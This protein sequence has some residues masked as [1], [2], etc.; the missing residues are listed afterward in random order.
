MKR[1][2]LLIFIII[3]S[4]NIFAQRVGQKLTENKFEHKTLY[5]A[6]DS[7]NVPSPLLDKYDVKF[8]KLDIDVERNNVYVAGNVLMNAKVVTNVLDTFAFELNSALIIDSLFINNQSYTCIRTGWMV[9]VPITALNIGVDLTSQVYYHGTC[10]TNNGNFFSGISSLYDITWTLSESFAANEWFPVKQS[11][12]DKIDSAYIFVTTSNENK[13][14]SE[15]ILT[16]VVS[17]PNNKVRYEWKERIPL[18]YYLISVAVAKYVD[19]SI[20]AHP[21]GASDSLLIQNY[22][23]DDTVT[24]ANNKLLID[25]TRNYIEYYSTIF[26]M[27]PFLKE[28][29][30]HC[31]TPL[32]GGMEHQTMTTLGGFD[33]YL[34]THE[35]SH[36]WFG[37]NVTCATWSDIWL[38]EGF[39]SYA[40]CLSAN[41]FISYAEAQVH[42]SD[43]HADIMSQPDGSVYIP[44]GQAID[45]NRIF[46]GRLSY[47]K[48]A[49][50]LHNLRF[51][52]NNDSVFFNVLKTYALLFKDSVATS[53][54]FEHVAEQVSGQNFTDLFNEWCFG[55]GFPTYSLVWSQKKDTVNLHLTQTT[56]STITPLFKG[57]IEYKL[58]LATGDT[59]IR[60]YNSLN[61]QDYSFVFPQTVT[62]ISIDP[63]NWIVNDIGS[64]L[65]YINEVDQPSF[66]VYPNPCNDA[67]TLKFVTNVINYNLNIID[68]MGKQ[69]ISINNINGNQYKLNTQHLDAGI[70]FLEI[71][72]G[73]NKS[74]KKFIKE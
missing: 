14:G 55:E 19:Y 11:L 24:L 9:Y 5:K 37:D 73:V 38:N 45:D 54:D 21:A 48:G 13:V 22:V 15:G 3:I 46:D 7:Y 57:N 20:Y 27:Y 16:N 43:W 40:E 60:L 2:I 64:I 68:I 62:D 31:L 65:H 66:E 47:H 35:L 23:Y 30:G 33:F 39:A 29:Y 58:K 63:N 1:I 74:I 72:N 4:N 42:M 28:K 8:Y 10:N 69:I 71:G 41:H 61:I 56:S 18:D 67:M 53:L 34:V 25:S 50:I 52:I 70:Y 51:E 36:Q 59:I 17:L 44:I 6:P 12:T 32:G 49:A 26:G